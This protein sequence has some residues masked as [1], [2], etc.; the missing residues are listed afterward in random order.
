MHC[1]HFVPLNPVQKA[2]LRSVARPA[3]ESGAIREFFS[4]CWTLLQE[5]S[6]QNAYQRHLV[7]QGVP[8]SGAEWRRF[9]DKKNKERYGQ[10]KCC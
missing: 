10:V 5:L 3:P 6:D 1:D 8:H 7:L 9:S 4:G 2:A